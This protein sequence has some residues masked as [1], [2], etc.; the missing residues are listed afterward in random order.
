MCVGLA[1]VVHG[2]G[3]IAPLCEAHRRGPRLRDRES[4]RQREFADQARAV[5]GVAFSRD[6][7]VDGTAVVEE[8]HLQRV[9][10]SIDVECRG[11]GRGNDRHA[12]RTPFSGRCLIGT[13]VEVVRSLVVVDREREEQR[14]GR[15]T[16]HVKHEHHIEHGRG[17]P[18]LIDYEIPMS[19]RAEREVRDWPRQRKRRRQ[20]CDEVIAALLAC[21]RTPADARD[22]VAVRDGGIARLASGN[23]VYRVS[24]ETDSGNERNLGRRGDAGRNQRERRPQDG[25]QC[26]CPEG[27]RGHCY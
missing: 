23:A 8:A 17:Q 12:V 10:H 9:I 24:P 6:E 2:D 4:R 21:R 18:G 25:N 27:L 22:R 15:H 20:R 19:K 3:E 5:D 13:G 16:V 11:I 1:R 7:F 26:Q 14:T